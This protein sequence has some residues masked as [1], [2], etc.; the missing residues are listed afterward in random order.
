MDFVRGEAE[1]Q[2]LQ[3]EELETELEAVR[4]QMLTLPSSGSDI[5]KVTEERN[6]DF[7]RFVHFLI[8]FVLGSRVRFLNAR[9]YFPP[10]A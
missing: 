7:A 1:R 8:L 5:W 4:H 3:R 10:G 6:L 9:F 2:R